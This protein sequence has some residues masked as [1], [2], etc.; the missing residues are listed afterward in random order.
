MK[1]KTLIETSFKHG[2]ELRYPTGL[3]LRFGECRYS[4]DT[5]AKVVVDQDGRFTL[6][7]EDGDRDDEYNPMKVTR[8]PLDPTTRVSRGYYPSER[9]EWETLSAWE[10]IAVLE[11]KISARDALDPDYSI[12]REDERV[13]HEAGW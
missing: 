11:T 1:T 6:V 5:Y 13:A 3:G 4:D 12:Q 8:Q 9:A 2:F 10:T 7:T